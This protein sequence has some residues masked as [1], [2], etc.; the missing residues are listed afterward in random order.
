[1]VVLLRLVSR[2]SLLWVKGFFGK[3]FSMLAKMGKGLYRKRGR[4]IIEIGFY[5]LF[6]LIFEVIG[7]SHIRKFSMLIS[8]A[9]FWKL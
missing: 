6:I 7:L 3:W 4:V 9:L 1:M 8:H 2:I 5:D